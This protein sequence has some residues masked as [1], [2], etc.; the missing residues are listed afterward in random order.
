VPCDNCKWRDEACTWPTV[1]RGKACRT[2]RRQRVSCQVDG[3]PVV[4]QGEPRLASKDG[5]PKRKKC[6]V[7][8]VMIDSETEGEAVE[9]TAELEA[10]PHNRAWTGPTEELPEAGEGSEV[11]RA[12]WAI[13]S[14]IQAIRRAQEAIARNTEAGRQAAEAQV[15][16]SRQA[17]SDLASMSYDLGALVEGRRYLRTWEMGPVEGESEVSVGLS[18]ED[19][20]ESED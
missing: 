2:C 16:V 20:E 14:D 7:S 3:K 19:S 8:K 4:G 1:G 9:A 15:D 17:L 12:L 5:S 13:A 10:R 18:E 11:A 6:K